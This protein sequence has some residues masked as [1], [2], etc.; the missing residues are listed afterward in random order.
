MGV[1][2]TETLESATVPGEVAIVAAGPRKLAR[3]NRARD[4]FPAAV[5]GASLPPPGLGSSSPWPCANWARGTAIVIVGAPRSV[6][7]V[8]LAPP[9]ARPL[10]RATA[11]AIPIAAW[12]RPGE[13]PALGS[14]SH[15]IHL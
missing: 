6:S 2:A 3:S 7:A 12:C 5:A 10:T 15:A 11:P 8:P 4:A 13:P 9:P 1:P 14:L